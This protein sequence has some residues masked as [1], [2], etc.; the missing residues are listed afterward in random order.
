MGLFSNDNFINN[1]RTVALRLIPRL[2]EMA[3][4]DV[5]LPVRITALS[6]IA[7]T[8]KTGI[9]QDEHEEQREK[10]ARLIFDHEPRVRKAVSAFFLGVWEERTEKLKAQWRSSRSTK[11]KRG[12][13]ITEEE[14]EAIIGWKSLAALLV[15]TAKSLEMPKDGA[16]TWRQPQPLLR[17]GQTVTHANAAVEAIWAE[18]G[19]LQEWQKLVE[20]LLLDH[21]TAAQDM[22]L[23]KDEEEDFMIQVL[24]ACVKQEHKVSRAE[25]RMIDILLEQE[26]ELDPRTKTLMQIL[27]RLFTKHQSDTARMAGILSIPEHMELALYLDMRKSAVGY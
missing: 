12:V 10:V 18:F 25:V 23:L 26:D 13:G 4:R 16:S 7:I 15:E 11:K 17:T 20:Y 22:W 9:L 21:S 19:T 24:I 8:D 14:M 3:L 1:A 27:P 5:D 6:V 2:V